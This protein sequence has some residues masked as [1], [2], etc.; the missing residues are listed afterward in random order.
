MSNK[1]IKVEGEEGL[2][3]DPVS[4]GIFADDLAYARYKADKEKRLRDISQEARINRLE[5][6][7]SE[8]RSGL[9]E[10]I[11]ILRS[12]NGNSSS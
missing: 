6:Q 9:D 10:L 5:Q 12:K 2:F 11:S 8:V 7:I 4:G 1:P 3:R